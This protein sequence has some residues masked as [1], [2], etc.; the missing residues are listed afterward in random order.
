MFGRISSALDTLLAMQEAMDSAMKSDYFE[1]ATTSRGSYPPVNIFQERESAVLT[2]EIP[3][4][5]KEDIRIEIK[6]KMIRLSGH[7]K[8]RYPEKAG[9]HRLERRDRKFDRAI[10][11]AFS[12]DAEKARA[13]FANGILRL[14]LPRMESDKPKLIQVS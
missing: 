8:I 1:R 3:G 6:D 14:T 11:M 12:I 5:K 9:V 10:K 7:R 4:V 13:E 2:A